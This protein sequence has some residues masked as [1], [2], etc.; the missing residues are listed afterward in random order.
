MTRRGFSH[1]V[2]SI[3]GFNCLGY[4]FL[5]FDW[6]YHLSLL[7]GA[8]S[9][10]FNAFKSSRTRFLPNFKPNTRPMTGMIEFKYPYWKDQQTCTFEFY[11]DLFKRFV[12]NFFVRHLCVKIC[13]RPPS[14][15][16]NVTLPR[17]FDCFAMNG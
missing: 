17:S 14:S 2:S 8:A 11:T 10:I 16:G 13:R 5:V 3:L 6:G 9:S 12:W 15:F 7:L 4:H 1:L